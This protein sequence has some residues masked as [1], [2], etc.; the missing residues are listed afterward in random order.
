MLSLAGCDDDES[1]GTPNPPAEPDRVQVQHVLIGFL[2]EPGPGQPE[3]HS[4]IPGLEITRSRDEAGELADSLFL[5]ATDGAPFDSLVAE[6]TEDSY[7]G[8]YGMSNFGISANRADN[9]FPRE[10]MVPSFGNVGFRL[11]VGGIGL[12]EY[13]P[14]QSPYGWHVIKRL[15]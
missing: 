1:S 5:E 12:A 13:H 2:T 7:P 15:R 6:Y 11:A 14:V 4:S 8:I 10:G 3:G 9:E